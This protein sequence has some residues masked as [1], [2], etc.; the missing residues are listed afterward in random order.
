ME[1]P[2]WHS[3]EYFHNSSFKKK[4]RK[5]ERKKKK[6]KLAVRTIFKVP[7]KQVVYVLNIELSY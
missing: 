5:K 1:N 2:T 4:K 6:K 3:K 7:R